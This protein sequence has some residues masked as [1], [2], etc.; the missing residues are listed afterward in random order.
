MKTKELTI[1]A[2]CCALTAILAPLT[3]TLPFTLIPFSLSLIPI[4]LTG[5]VLP[6]RHAFLAIVLYV[7]LGL[8]GLPVFSGFASGVGV[9]AGP[10]GGF[11][12]GYP[13][14]ALA[15]AWAVEKRFSLPR[16][17]IGAAIGMVVCYLPA[18]SGMPFR[19]GCRM[20]RLCLPQSSPLCSGTRSK[21]F[22]RARRPPLC[23]VRFRA[24]SS[25]PCN[26]NLCTGQKI[27]LA[28]YVPQGGFLSPAVSSQARQ[29]KHL[30]KAPGKRQR[31][32]ERSS[33]LIRRHSPSE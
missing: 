26:Q 25:P 17:A 28:V 18:R 16:Y 2:L 7:L 21:P 20:G 14:T 11:V 9:L 8:I 4:F 29:A 1:T 22:W 10:T 3:I 12:I 31:D 13:F 32:G 5:A 23:A 30:W 15:V 6:K 24:C 27:P 19:R 33:C